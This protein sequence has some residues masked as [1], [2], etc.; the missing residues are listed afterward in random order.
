MHT[1]QVMSSAADDA[2]QPPQ[3]LMLLLYTVQ[4][5]SMLD[6]PRSVLAHIVSELE[7]QQQGSLRLVCK[8]LAVN[9]RVK[10][11]SV[12]GSIDA[13]CSQRL[14][15]CFPAL[16]RLDLQGTFTAPGCQLLR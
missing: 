10:H 1:V 8:A 4:G 7:P 9:E 15:Y 2:G 6:M 12:Q 11:I 13:V 14:L 5:P 3:R 16:H